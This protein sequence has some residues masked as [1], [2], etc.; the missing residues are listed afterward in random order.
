M[1]LPNL[2]VWA[3][4]ERCIPKTEEI[5][6][7][8]WHTPTGSRQSISSLLAENQLHAATHAGHRWTG[9]RTHPRLMECG[10]RMKFLTFAVGFK[11]ELP[12]TPQA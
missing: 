10:P 4:P 3:E 8:L 1:D 5:R 2:D 12:F 11:P 7:P 9:Y 6:P